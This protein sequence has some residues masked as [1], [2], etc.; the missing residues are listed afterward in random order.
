VKAIAKS[1]IVWSV[2]L[3]VFVGSFL[4]RFLELTF[5]N[6]HFEYLALADEI[7]QG[8]IPGVDFFDPTRPLQYYLSAAGLWLFG[9]QLLA[10]ALLCVT[11]LSFAT[12]VVFFLGLEVSGAISLGTVAA[13]FVV[14]VLPR[15]YAY[16]K[17][18][19]PALGLWVCWRYLDRPSTR[20]LVALALVTAA[21]FYLRFDYGVWLGI[22]VVAAFVV[23]FW[24][25]WRPLVLSGMQY[26][27]A[28]AALCSPYLALQ[29]ALGGGISSGPGTGRLTHLL[30]GED[31]VSL[32]LPRL[33]EERPLIW[34]RP[35]GPLSTVRWRPD[36]TDSRRSAVERQY[37]LRMVR[38]IDEH[39]W[40]YVLVDRSADALKRLMTDPAVEGTTNIDGEGRILREPP[41]SVVRRWLHVP[42]MESPL[43]SLDN[44]TI[45]FYDVLFLTP[46]AAAALLLVRRARG[47]NPEGEAAKIVAAI[48]IAILFNVFLIR[49]N[50]DSHL[51]DVIVPGAVLWVWMLRGAVRH[52]SPMRFGAA[53]AALVSIWLAVDVYAG[54]MNQLE[55]SELF[56]TPTHVARRFVGTMRFLRQEPLEQFA[57]A[58]STGLR[59]LTRYVNRCTQPSDFLLV[60]GYQPE[61][62]FYANRRIGGGNVVYQANLGAAPR[63]QA[64]IVSRLQRESVPVA[65]LPMN[66]L[67]ELEQTYPI[68]REYVE[69]RYEIAG[70]SGFGEGRPFRV[71]V[72]RRA[73]PSHIDPEMG[74]PCF[75]GSAPQL[76]A[77]A[78]P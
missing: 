19:V 54:S 41:W 71:L 48:V 35:A 24:Q 10:E 62:F 57:P 78:I 12:T 69:A 67:K 46:F 9:H 72:D 47:A 29:A 15:L 6:D 36:V 38:S 7:L 18:I 59:G 25:Q 4:V 77:R 53:A 30:E 14:A 70:E 33:P 68:V 45:W 63:Q 23:R 21:S 8:A 50:L 56:S 16:P 20:R 51:P 65:I 13:G 27:I 3:G 39:A 58:G 5:H 42:V 52:F 1:R 40:Q 60:L 64:L 76:A 66:R 26:G 32:G 55:A 75:T 2:A 28:V 22:A 11:L 34:F 73:I 49:G 17:M 74:L 61:M 37:S 44:A 43:L 31:V